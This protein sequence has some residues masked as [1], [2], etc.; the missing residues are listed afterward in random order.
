[1]FPF[2]FQARQAFEDAGILVL[3]GQ[4]VCYVFQCALLGTHPVL[5]S[6]TGVVR[7]V[8]ALRFV[9]DEGL[10]SLDRGGV[11]LAGAGA[12]EILGVVGWIP[13]DGVAPQ[14]LEA[15]SQPS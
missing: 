7:A 12:R 6:A 13:D 9:Y 2:L 5:G 1:M 15:Y 8:A 10:V 14:I 11:N 3:S 4:E